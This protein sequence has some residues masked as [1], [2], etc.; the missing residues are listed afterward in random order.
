MPRGFWT[1]VWVC[2]TATQ[3]VLGQGLAPLAPAAS[4]FEV[5]SVKE[6]HSLEIDGVFNRTGGR[7]IAS[8]LELRSL[9][10]YAYRI[11]EYQLVNVPEWANST[12]YSIEATVADA[13]ASND[14]V[15]AM[16]QNLLAE[17]FG[18][19]THREQRDLPMYALVVARDDRR[20]GAQLVPV[21]IDCATA[22][23]N[24]FVTTASFRA[25]GTLLNGFVQQL[26]LILHAPIVDRTALTGRFNINVRWSPPGGP[27]ADPRDASVEQRA[28]IFSALPEQLGLRLQSVRGPVEVVVIDS[29]A[30]PTPD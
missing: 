25:T 19:R 14:A 21:E 23:C 24:A 22:P 12:R 10:Q 30:R 27:A 2:T 17:R 20:L 28:A 3:L 5:A 4:T 26:E 8:N 9:I 18:L 15:R 16:V 13:S 29:L 6:S 7:F 1:G 11:R